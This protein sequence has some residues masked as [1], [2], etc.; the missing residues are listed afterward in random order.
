MI[1]NCNK[2]LLLKLFLVGVFYRNNRNPSQ[3]TH[4]YC[5]VLV[6]LTM[7]ICKQF[8]FDCCYTR[9]PEEFVVFGLVW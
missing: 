5:L 3:D 8:F 2:P 6:I 7:H 4:I 9:S 1:L